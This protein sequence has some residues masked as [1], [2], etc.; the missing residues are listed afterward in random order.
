MLKNKESDIRNKSGYK[1][2][3]QKSRQSSM[4]NTSSYRRD[5][6]R[7]VDLIYEI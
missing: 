3:K 1:I 7:V 5:N 2:G 4:R 6:K